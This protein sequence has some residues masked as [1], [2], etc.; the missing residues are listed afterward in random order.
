MKTAT[1]TKL[2]NG[3]LEIELGFDGEYVHSNPN[4]RQIYRRK[5]FIVEPITNNYMASHFGPKIG[6]K[7]ISYYKQV[8]T[9]TVTIL[10]DGTSEVFLVEGSALYNGVVETT[11]AF[12]G[13]KFRQS[14][15]APIQLWR[16][17][18]SGHQQLTSFPTSSELESLATNGE[19]II[20]NGNHRYL[21]DIEGKLINVSSSNRDGR[22]LY[23]NGKFRY[24]LGRSIFEIKP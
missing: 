19:A 11:G 20:I 21:F 13:Y 6:E 7:Y 24:L 23:D 10:N 8:D 22:V 3:V 12:V 5:G 14:R 1:H 15:N 16:Y 2:S 9:D 18:P 17:G 4:D